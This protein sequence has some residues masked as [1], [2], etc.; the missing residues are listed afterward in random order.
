MSFS[1]N[2]SSY[3]LNTNARADMTTRE[4][5][6]SLE[7]LS[8]GLRINK[9]ADDASGLLIANNLRM[10][11]SSLNQAT[12]NAKSAVN[13]VQIA[14]NALEEVDKLL[15]TIKTKAIQAAEDGQTEKTR[16]AIQK[17]V[18]KL[19]QSLDNISNTTKYNGQNLLSGAFTNKE[20]QIGAYSNE[21][22]KV[23]IGNT[24]SNHIGHT[25]METIDLSDIATAEVDFTGTATTNDTVAAGESKMV[26]ADAD[27]NTIA[28]SAAGGELEGVSITINNGDDIAFA[29]TDGDVITFAASGE[30][31]AFLAAE[32]TNNTDLTDNGNG[33]YSLAG[34]G[35]ITSSIDNLKITVIELPNTD[36]TT[37]D[38]ALTITD[39]T[40]DVNGIYVENNNDGALTLTGDT[41]EV[42]TTEIGDKLSMNIDGLG[43][44]TVEI[45]NT[46]G[47]G[48]GALADLINSNSDVVGSTA[49][50]DVSMRS[51]TAIQEGNVSNL[52][53]NDV[54]IGNV[55]DIVENDADGK[56]VNAIN[57]VS[58]ET[59]VIAS[60]DA[61]GFLQLDSADGRSIKIE[62]DDLWE[63]MRI[64]SG[65]SKTEVGELTLTSAGAS[66]ILV[67]MS[68]SQFDETAGTYGDSFNVTAENIAGQTSEE[69]NNL[70][71]LV[72]DG[73][74]TTRDGA[75]KAMDIADAAL[76]VIDGIRSDIGSTQ[77][78]LNS[79]IN[80]ITMT[81]A[82][83]QVA[84][85]GIRDVD[86]AVE[87]ANFNKYKL[88]AQSGTYAMSQA[89][90][91][92]QNVMSLLR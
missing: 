28:I 3:S 7:K 48:V 25:K 84:E 2:T 39:A 88:L 17:D 77:Q 54:V 36:T 41:F 71:S 58:H 49:S 5:S 23:S 27:G 73:L 26:A 92:Q 66:D 83:V 69:I 85:G 1:I 24:D 38:G 56:L 37:D 21:T 70:F 72:S 89:N 67:N 9:A 78:Q 63:S 30:S 91:V 82:N 53:I 29:E 75:Q 50:F 12:S 62:A 80:N 15:T 6:N 52:V 20:F 16:L 65:T 34:G 44:H 87:T 45:G 79:T 60:V 14:D 18:N 43:L 22:V 19:I 51:A 76:E 35:N 8:S 61:N 81:A 55:T 57:S 33:T 11:A 86:F 13:L 47:T 40:A 46:A 42:T 10:Q 31:A 68:V 32:A 59:G 64:G 90:Q 4:I 74:L